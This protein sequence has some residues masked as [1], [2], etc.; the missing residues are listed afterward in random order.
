MHIL[1]S[2]L[3]IKHNILS[4]LTSNYIS[5]ESVYSLDHDTDH[6]HIAVNELEN[7]GKVEIARGIIAHIRLK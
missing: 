3:L 4:V 6:S 2:I 1:N 5:I 7:E